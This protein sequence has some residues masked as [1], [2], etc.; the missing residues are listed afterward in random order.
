MSQPGHARP[1]RRLARRLR[2]CALRPPARGHARIHPAH[3]AR[4]HRA[5]LHSTYYR[6]DN[7]IL[8]IGGDI[9]AADAF[10]LAERLFGD[11]AKARRAAARR[12]PRL[13]RT[14]AAAASRASSSWTCRTRGRRRS[15]S[16]AGLQAHRPGIL[17]RHR[18]QLGARRRLFGRL[19]QEIRIKRGLSYGARSALDVRRDVGPFVASTQTKNPS[20]ARSRRC[21]SASWTGCRASRH[22]DGADA[23]QGCAHRQLR[24]ALETTDGPRRADRL[25]RALRAE[26]RRDQQLHQERAGGHGRRRSEVRGLASRR[27]GREHHHRR[28]R[29]GLHRRCAS[30]S[31]TSK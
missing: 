4:R 25:A 3:Q 11:W 9:K 8:V 5:S 30:S 24:R 29:Q 1:L 6:P 31:R 7:A 27:E 22:R 21:S 16:R 20:G 19:N 12:T 15:C 26:P 10:K 23:A 17:P 18:R 2:R 14:A 13:P 28:Q